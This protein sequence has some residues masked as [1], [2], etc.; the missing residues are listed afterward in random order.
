MSMENKIKVCAI[1][2]ARYQSSRFPGKPLAIINGKPMI[3]RVYE[4][5]AQAIPQTYVATDSDKI[6]SVCEDK[7]IP[8]LMTSSDALTG[9]D[10]VYEA[11]QQLDADIIINVQGDEP[12]ILADDINSVLQAKLQHPTE[13]VNGVAPITNE[14][15]WLSRDVPKVVMSK[16]NCL[17]Y[18]SRAPIPMTKDGKFTGALRQVCIYAFTPQEL[19]LFAKNPTKTPIE[20]IED[21]E[22]LRF[23]EIDYP[24]RMAMVSGHS[25]AVDRPGDIK[26]VEALLND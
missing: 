16:T 20:S 19:A 5:T 26:K 25:I 21:I 18:M 8:V 22:I 23:L 6:K 14:Q 13:V 3:Q 24:I 15:D 1:I 4:R 12:L 2:P 7:N 10:R 17:L 9:T 11:S